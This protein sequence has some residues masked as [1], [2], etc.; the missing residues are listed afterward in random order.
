MIRRAGAHQPGS[1]PGDAAMKAHTRHIV[2]AVVIGLV[3]L[4]IATVAAA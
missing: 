4:V 1:P 2:I 3:L